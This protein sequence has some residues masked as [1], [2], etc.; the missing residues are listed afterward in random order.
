MIQSGIAV[1]LDVLYSVRSPFWKSS[2]CKS[3][4]FHCKVIAYF[5]QYFIILMTAPLPL[6]CLVKTIKY[7]LSTMADTAIA[8]S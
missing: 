1:L 4:L 7:A 2:H 5:E 8:A 6:I 3:F